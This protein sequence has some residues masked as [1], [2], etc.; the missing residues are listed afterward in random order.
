MAMPNL[1][2]RLTLE[3]PVATPDGAG[4]LVESWAPLGE[5]W[6]ELRPGTGGERAGS[7]FALARAPYRI[8]VRSA[9]TGSPSRPQP[10]QRFREGTR[11]FRILAVSDRDDGGRYLTCFSVEE[12]AA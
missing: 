1:T 4:G 5:L 10:N 7:A 11:L 6:A 2:R 8:T 12:V 9:P 3:E